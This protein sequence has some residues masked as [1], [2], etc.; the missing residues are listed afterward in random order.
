MRHNSVSMG[1]WMLTKP[2]EAP[3]HLY[4]IQQVCQVLFLSCLLNIITLVWWRWSKLLYLWVFLKSGVHFC[5]VCLRVL[6]YLILPRGT[7]VFPNLLKQV[8][9]I[10]GLWISERWVV[11]KDFWASQIF[12]PTHRM[13]SIRS[14]SI[15]FDICI[16]YHKLK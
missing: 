3:C 16:F 2:S 11:V 10:P 9:V 12:K 13:S 5:F 15:L 7:E 8:E 4:Q 14:I 1:T 6:F